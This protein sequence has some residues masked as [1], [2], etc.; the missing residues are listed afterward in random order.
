MQHQQRFNTK[1]G[2][3]LFYLF[4]LVSLEISINIEYFKCNEVKNLFWYMVISIYNLLHFSTCSSP[5]WLS[6]NNERNKKKLTDDNINVLINK[7]SQYLFY[8]RCIFQRNEKKKKTKKL[9]GALCT[10]YSHLY[11]INVVNRSVL[12]SW[13]RCSI[14]TKANFI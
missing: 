13:I 1:N 11:V 10:Y 7:C 2:N 8:V 12:F 9:E 3:T 6:T 4:R 5:D 14:L